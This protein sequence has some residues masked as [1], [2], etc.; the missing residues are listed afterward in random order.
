MATDFL[1]LHRDVRRA[2]RDRLKTAPGYPGQT[3]VD[4]EGGDFKAETVT[5][6]WWRERFVPLP[7]QTRSLGPNARVTHRGT[8]LVDVFVPAGNG[9]KAAD[10]A[11]GNII[12][13]FQPNLELV[14][15]GRVVTVVEAGRSRA[16]VTVQW[17]QIPLIVSWYV[18]SINTI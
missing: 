16:S 14:H 4:W 17:V 8:Y 11:A 9:L 1:T 10:L 12:G 13:T 18:H 15:N 3:M 6:V 2:L 5:T 7:G